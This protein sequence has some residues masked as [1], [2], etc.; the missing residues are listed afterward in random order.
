[1][2][3]RYGCK[4]LKHPL[5]CLVAPAP[6]LPIGP[7][8]TP[9]LSIIVA[10]FNAA[11]TIGEALESVLS[12]NPAPFEVIV[13]DDGSQDNLD[14]A[15]RCFGDRISVVRGPH[16]GASVARNRGAAA[17]TGELLGMLDADDIWRPGRAA[18]LTAAAAARPDISIFTTDAV[19]VRNG[20]CDEQT[21]YA[22]RHFDVDDQE[23]AILRSNFIFGAGAFRRQSFVEVG[24]Y[25]PAALWAGDWNLW[26][27]LILNG[28]RAGLVRLPLYE[29]RRRHGSLTNQKTN[30]AMGVLAM[31]ARIE[32][33]ARAR[34]HAAVL[35]Q[36]RS[37]WQRRL[38]RAALRS[39]GLA[40]LVRVSLL[41]NLMVSMLPRLQTRGSD[42]DLLPPEGRA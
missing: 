19:V 9:K 42:G 13:S 30:L 37:E 26:L 5:D 1:M 34:G 20:A 33:V 31:L 40:P 4:Q 15:V 16:C 28:H 35:R 41:A 6:L 29:Y 21:Y 7:A 18:A 39:S 24:G 36:T 23:I 14:D 11:E 25:D 22:V 2:T 27:R 32:P 8:D 10:A 17:A 12:Q 38:A 3:R